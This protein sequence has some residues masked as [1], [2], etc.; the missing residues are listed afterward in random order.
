MA[1][2][3]PTDTAKYKLI[4]SDFDG[5]LAGP[6]HI[7]TPKV[8][9]AVKRW[10]DSGRHF[11]IATGR[12]FLMIEDECNKM[13]L[14]DPVVVRGGAEVTDPI[15]GKDLH[16]EP[17]SKKDVAYILD[18]FQKEDLFLYTIEVDDIIYTNFD[19]EIAHLFPKITYK[20]LSE[21]SSETVLKFHVKPKDQSDERADEIIKEIGLNLPEVH[22]IATHNKVFGKGWDVT[23][24]RATKLYGIVKLM[25]HLN[26]SREEIVGVGDSYND[27]P[28]L[29]AAGLK[30]AMGN[31]NDELKAIAD[32]MVSS[33]KDDGIAELITKLLQS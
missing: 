29:E 32:V 10:V 13:G 1:N 24:V 25:D 16:I 33:H 17:I 3:F 15:T 31:A 14:V 23:S 19:F 5:T 11:T 27:F 9:Q 7:V 21:F 28:L 30:V 22:I 8:A 26:V 20:G 12:Q 18:R 2:S 4:V 6:D